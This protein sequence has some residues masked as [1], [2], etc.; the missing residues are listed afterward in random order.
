MQAYSNSLDI[1]AQLGGYCQVDARPVH[2]RDSHLPKWQQS[3]FPRHT[4]TSAKIDI[5]CRERKTEL[6]GYMDNIRRGSQEYLSL[7]KFV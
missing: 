6:P 4:Y 5:G 7:V 2:C 1:G 3:K